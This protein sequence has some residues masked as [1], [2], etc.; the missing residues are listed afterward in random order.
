MKTYYKWLGFFVL[1]G[2][3]AAFNFFINSQYVSNIRHKTTWPVKLNYSRLLFCIILTSPKNLKNTTRPFTVLD[4][5]AH[6]CSNYRFI[7][8]LPNKLKANLNST[9]N[10][11]VPEPLNLYQ[12]HGFSEET[13]SNYRLTKKV[14]LAFRDI[15]TRHGDYHFYLK[16]DDDTFVHVENLKAYLSELDPSLPATYGADMKY[17]VKNGYPS[18]GAGYVLSNKAM[19]LLGERLLKNMSACR[20]SGVEDLSKIFYFSSLF[21]E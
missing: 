14:F 5:W 7:T 15:Y 11:L 21:N 12:P 6:K 3:F 17:K 8:V 13:N 10:L 2:L 20:N 4:T 9:K 18:G 16:A 19:S 1:V